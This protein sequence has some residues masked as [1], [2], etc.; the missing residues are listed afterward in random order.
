MP[1]IILI[2]R[3]VMGGHMRKIFIFIIFL[4][5]LMSHQAFSVV[6]CASSSIG[7]HG[8][9]QLRTLACCQ[10]WGESKYKW[11]RLSTYATSPPINATCDDSNCGGASGAELYLENDKYDPIIAT[12]HD[13][14]NGGG[15]YY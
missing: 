8:E 4:F 10:G 3:K 9:Q 6:Q 13:I 15:T 14:S 11:E 5:V 1:A 7:P 2:R 12:C